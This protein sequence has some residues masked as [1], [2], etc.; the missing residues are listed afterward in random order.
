M[1]TRL[2]NTQ[3]GDKPVG[4]TRLDSNFYGQLYLMALTQ[5]LTTKMQKNFSSLPLSVA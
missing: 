4:I 2:R 1:G 3:V 5:P